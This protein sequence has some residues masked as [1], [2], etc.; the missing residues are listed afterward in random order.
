MFVAAIGV[1]GAVAWIVDVDSGRAAAQENQA[2]APPTVAPAGVGEGRNDP[3]LFPSTVGEIRAA[4]LFV[5]FADVRGEPDVRAAYEAFVPEAAAWYSRVSYGRLR[6]SVTPLEQ[7]L[8][9][10]GTVA[11]YR[12]GGGAGI[13]A[14]LRAAL[15]D[16]VAAADAALDFSG[17]HTVYLVLPY[18]ALG[19]I[20][21]SGVLILD[22]PVRV[23]DTDIRIF[24]VLFDGNGAQATY[25][26]HETGHVLG[27][28]DLYVSGRQ[29]TFHRWDVMAWPLFM[30]GLFAWHR[31][32]LGWLEPAQIVCFTQGIRIAADLTSLDRPGGTK[33]IVL[34]RGRYAYV[35]E[36]RSPSLARD[37]RHT[38]RGGV[39][40]YRVEFGAASGAADIV[41]QPA[42]YDGSD[43]RVRCGLGAAAPFRLGRGQV[44][45]TRAWGL[46]LEVLAA[47]PN[48]AFRVR[49]TKTTRT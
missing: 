36:V 34:R 38:C 7:R 11:D 29:D 1:A 18:R 49:M 40:F 23:D 45:R 37:E 33:A 47:R 27:L 44:S 6:L 24:A 2:C 19:A 3:A 42:R 30:G 10:S 32:K 5:D 16:S 22:R 8:A 41:L 20:G 48:G 12:S 35:A 39:L 13:E 31:W 9:L 17:F 15:Q 43:D 46:R 25:F 28:P 26:A 14:G 4:M 21:G